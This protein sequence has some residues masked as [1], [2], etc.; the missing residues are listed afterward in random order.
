MI[1]CGDI[2]DAAERDNS[3]EMVDD[4]GTYVPG[5]FRLLS[6]VS[7]ANAQHG[8]SGCSTVASQERQN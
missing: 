5:C 8:G 1:R 2:Y 3:S 6:S 7:A 4:T